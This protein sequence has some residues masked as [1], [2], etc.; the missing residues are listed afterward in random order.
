VEPPQNEEGRISPQTARQ[1][2]A[3]AVRLREGDQHGEL[4]R[5][6]LREHQ[7]LERIF[8]TVPL[9]MTI[10]EPD[11]NVLRVNRAFERLIGWSSDELAGISLMEECYPDSEYREKAREYMQACRPEWQDFHVTTR[12]GG[13]VESSW[14]NVRLPDGTQLGVGLD[15]TERNR[16][17]AALRESGEALRR[18]DRL[19]DEFLA[20]LAHE[21]RNP[22]SPMRNALELLRGDAAP[23]EVAASALSILDR[24]LGLMVR[25]VDDLLDLSRITTGKIELQRCRVDVH[26]IVQ[27]A[28]DS[29]HVLFEGKQ[30]ICKPSSG[31]PLYIDGDPVRLE[32]I[33]AN[34]LNNAAKFTPKGGTIMLD[35][36]REAEHAVVR[37]R[38]TGI[39]VAPEVLPRIFDMF[40]Q[41]ERGVDRVRGGLGIGLS[42]VKRLV[43]LHEGSVEALSAGVGCG[44]EF[45]V[46]LPLPARA[47]E[48]AGVLDESPAAWAPGAESAADQRKRTVLVVDDN[49]DAAESLVRLLSAWGHDAVGVNDGASAVELARARAWDVIVMDI[50]MPGMSG[51]DAARQIRAEPRLANVLLI[52]LTGWGQPEARRESAQA[53]F[54][55]HLVKPV[56]AAVLRKLLTGAPP[57]R[58]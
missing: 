39:G 33:F 53:G 5:V 10:Y 54:D 55:L 18:A 20:T 28:V 3:P 4:Q 47:K 42:L 7:L 36:E 11:T 51:Y 29:G 48:M 30:L 13:V 25:L 15:I 38:D 44:S 26:T 37:V 17:D 58:P 43:E 49:V 34:L 22:L 45:V 52:A 19:K 6:S 57:G 21:L 24:Q 56:E 35:I 16:A 12:Y 9:M 27:K 1:E 8:D 32:Q 50:G 41:G 31:A 14:T 46:R 23:P 40:V 2:S